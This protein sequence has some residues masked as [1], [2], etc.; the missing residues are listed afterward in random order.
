METW[1]AVPGFEGKYEVS[2]A[3][4]VKSL[5]RRGMDEHLLT[6]GRSSNGYLTVTL[7]GQGA[8]RSY[9]VQE[10]VTLAFIGPRP[11]D[12]Y[13]RHLDGNRTNNALTNLTYGTAS[14]NYRDVYDYGKTHRKLTR[15]DVQ[16]I[17]AK[18]RSGLSTHDIAKEYGVCERAVRNIREG[19]TFKW[20]K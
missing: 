12:T 9:M 3:G 5:P 11:P 14:E 19:R 8:N 20:L 10:L 17:R 18:L 7:Y 2:D 13:I 16:D 4:M 1:R 15:D 6:P